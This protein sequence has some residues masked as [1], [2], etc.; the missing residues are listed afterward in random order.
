MC[1]TL[2][3]VKGLLKALADAQQ[4]A[5]QIDMSSNG[6]I[7]APA[8]EAVHGAPVGPGKGRLETPPSLGAR[9]LQRVTLDKRE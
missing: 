5:D 8:P 7:S 4:A 6:S 9:Q 1:H 3:Q 2:L